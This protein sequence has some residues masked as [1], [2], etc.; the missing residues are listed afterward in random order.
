M[1]DELNK[2]GIATRDE[3]LSYLDTAPTAEAPTWN[4]IGQ[5]FNDLT[6]ALNPIRKDS[7]YIHQ[8]MGHLPLPV[9]LRNHPSRRSWTRLIRY[10]CLLLMLDGNGKRG[11]KAKPP[12]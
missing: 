2:T 7:H 1:S 12:S 4:L 6:E 11:Q 9:T 8:K 3:L 5:G 10:V